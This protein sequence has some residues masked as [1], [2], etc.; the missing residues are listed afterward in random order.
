VNRQVKRNYYFS[1]AANARFRKVTGISYKTSIFFMNLG[2]YPIALRTKV[3][4]MKTL[5]DLFSAFKES[6]KAMASER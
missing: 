5:Q 3:Q 4:K 6:S 2:T 1:E